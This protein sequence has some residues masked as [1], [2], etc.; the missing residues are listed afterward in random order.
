MSFPHDINGTNISISNID[1]HLPACNCWNN[2]TG[3]PTEYG[4]LVDP[5]GTNELPRLLLK[6]GRTDIKKRCKKAYHGKGKG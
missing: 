4:M 6:I 1:T 2:I 3:S 5:V